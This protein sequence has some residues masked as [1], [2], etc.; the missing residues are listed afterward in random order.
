MGRKADKAFS[1]SATLKL[2]PAT[3]TP[4]VLAVSIDGKPLHDS[5]KIL[6][7]VGTTERPA[8]WETRPV[9]VAGRPG[10]EAVNFGHAPWMIA[11]NDVRISINNP[12]LSRAQ[13]LDPNGMPVRD[14]ALEN[15]AGARSLRFPPDVLYVILQ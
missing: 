14:L 6:V 1:S 7:Q 2:S 13:V 9:T 8:G 4:K 3:I 5:A 15:A 10:E 11:R 12:T